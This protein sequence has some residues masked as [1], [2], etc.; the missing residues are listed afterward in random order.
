MET[1]ETLEKRGLN[2]TEACNYIGGVSR[3]TMYKLLGE[4]S[5]ESYNLGV[6]RYFTKESLDKL[7][8]ERIGLEPEDDDS[9]S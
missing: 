5:I 4:G 2:M 7:I 6:R 9:L 3:P 1:K 8:N